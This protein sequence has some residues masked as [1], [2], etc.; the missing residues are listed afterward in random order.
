MAVTDLG[1]ETARWLTLYRVSIG[2]SQ[3]ELAERMG[4]AQSWVSAMES[5]KFNV[6]VGMLVDWAAALG[7]RP[8]ITFDAAG[9]EP[10]EEDDP[11]G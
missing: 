8:V 6:R 10:V 3:R 5:A 1:R 11:A 7:L 9:P 2:L 4:V